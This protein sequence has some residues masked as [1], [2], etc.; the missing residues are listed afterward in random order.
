VL[1]ILLSL[2][3]FFLYVVPVAYRITIAIVIVFTN[4]AIFDL[5]L[6]FWWLAHD[7]SMDLIV[8]IY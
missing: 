8:Y 3:V 6:A 1:F 2:F 5:W 7:L 4:L